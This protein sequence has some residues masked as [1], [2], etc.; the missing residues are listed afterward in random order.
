[1]TEQSSSKSGKTPIFL[2]PISKSDETIKAKPIYS[3]SPTPTTPTTPLK[4]PASATPAAAAAAP[5]PQPPQVSSNAPYYMPSGKEDKTGNIIMLIC[6]L[7]STLIL[8][9]SAFLL[10]QTQENKMSDEVMEKLESIE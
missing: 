8:G 3:E 7:I 6:L 5:I 9:T 4:R 2:K 10:Y 1:M